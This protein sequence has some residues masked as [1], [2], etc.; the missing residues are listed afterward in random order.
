MA[1][2]TTQPKEIDLDSTDK[3]PILQ[4]ISIDEDVEDDSIRL[5]YGAQGSPTRPALARR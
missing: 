4:G 1:I 3:L 5:D 2:D